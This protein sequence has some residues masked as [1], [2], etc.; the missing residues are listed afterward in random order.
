[1]GAENMI[2]KESIERKTVLAGGALVSLFV[3]AGGSGLASSFMLGDNVASLSNTS[4][5]LQNHLTADMMHDALRSDVLMSLVAGDPSYGV[6]YADVK[7]AVIEHGDELAQ[8][9]AENDRLATG[10]TKVALAA[11]AKPLTDYV[12]MAKQIVDLAGADPVAARGQLKQ[13]QV[14]FELL[15]VA[16][17]DASDAIAAQS[18]RT[19][20]DSAQEAVMFKWL[21]A[22]L[23]MAG[24]AGCVALVFAARRT[25][26][27][28]LAELSVLMGRLT[29]GDTSIETALAARSDE[30]GSMAQAV[31]V[32]RDAAIAKTRLEAEQVI[33][34]KR[35]EQEQ[36]DAI[37]RCEALVVETFGESLGRLANGELVYR[38]NAELP[39]AYA[40]LQS[41]YNTAMERLQA[42]MKVVVAN[43]AG[44]EG[45]AEEIAQASDDLSRRTEQQ[46]ASL[47]ET[48][49]ALD[50]ITAT[51][52][53]TATGAKRANEVVVAARAEAATGGAVVHDAVSAMSAIEKSSSQI[54]Q[55][56]GVIDE[57]AFQTNLLALNAG[58]EAARAG[59]AGRGFAV[60]AQEVRALAQ[61]SADAAKEIKSLI[62]ASST[63]VG[64]GVRLVDQ[65]GAALKQ[66]VARVQEIESVVAEIAASAQEQ[67]TALAEVN[68]AVNQMDQATQQNAAMVEQSTAATHSLKGEAADLMRLMGGFSIGASERV[69]PMKRPSARRLPASSARTTTARAATAAAVRS[70]ADADNWEE[71]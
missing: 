8:R 2:S 24:V 53:K 70:H 68:T 17:S 48:A 33:A 42:T 66:I 56:I 45:G 12:S 36:R 18:A 38:M 54:S 14:Q 55:I 50:Q 27:A 59:E 62:S 71:F 49:A 22:L 26:V 60:V 32:F 41:D 20:A 61:R 65:S 7:S 69:V 67:S 43:A 5:E 28:P 4:R 34:A 46:A 10:A 31:S 29:R 25:V 11:V 21:M 23:A 3:V 9:V 13:F 35:S 44:I 1:M 57:I 47:E 15:E 52:R 19:Q 63:Q 58:V 37:A 39:P 40:K 6:S 30:I 64:E 16:M 51:V